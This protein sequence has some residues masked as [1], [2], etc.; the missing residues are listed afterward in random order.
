L[1]TRR[2][3]NATLTRFNSTE[4]TLS[5]KIAIH[6]NTR[7]FSTAA[8][9]SE[10]AV[11]LN[12][13]ERSWTEGKVL[14]AERALKFALE[15]FPGSAAVLVGAISL[16]DV[17]GSTQEQADILKMI[18][19]AFEKDINSIEFGTSSLM[20]LLQ[21]LYDSAYVLGNMGVYSSALHRLEIATLGL[22]HI[23][24]AATPQF[25]ELRAAIEKLLKEQRANVTS[26]KVDSI[27]RTPV[28]RGF[29]SAGWE[30][31]QDLRT[32]ERKDNFDKLLRSSKLNN[33]IGSC[34][35]ADLDFEAAL[36]LMRD[37]LDFVQSH[38]QLQSREAAQA[39][40]AEQVARQAG[41][42]MIRDELGRT[43]QLLDQTS[44]F[45]PENTDSINQV[46]KILKD[47]K[48]AQKAMSPM[49]R[50]FQRPMHRMLW[51]RLQSLVQ[52]AEGDIVETAII[53]EI[54]RLL[55][56]IAIAL[57]PDTAIDK[58]MWAGY[59]S[60]KNML[61]NRSEDAIIEL[62]TLAQ[63][64]SE[65]GGGPP[66]AAKKKAIAQ[67][68]REA[69]YIRAR[70]NVVKVIMK[71]A[72]SENVTVSERLDAISSANRAI[73]LS[74]SPTVDGKTLIMRS[75]LYQAAGMAAE[76]MRDASLAAATYTSDA[77]IRFG[78]SAVVGS[79]Q[80]TESDLAKSI[81]LDAAA[82]L[83][84]DWQ[85]SRLSGGVF[86]S[87]TLPTKDSLDKLA[88]DS[89]K[90]LVLIGLELNP[91]TPTRAQ[92]SNAS[93]CLIYRYAPGNPKA[94]EDSLEDALNHL[95]Q[96]FD[97]TSLEDDRLR[98]FARAGLLLNQAV[99]KSRYQ[100]SITQVMPLIQQAEEIFQ[101]HG[102]AAPL[103]VPKLKADVASGQSTQNIYPWA[104]L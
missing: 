39:Y 101:R 12:Q 49:S 18:R 77:E 84:S 53:D 76:A 11:L 14:E 61:F 9:D 15:N 46:K 40:V 67:L 98:D 24:P 23:P 96:H 79:I 103:H 20:N 43:E 102:R 13:I 36:Y 33:T 21:Y 48:E 87:H 68:E 56:Q 31:R 50:S 45:L 17:V 57:D 73:A 81:F 80:G 52:Q 29:S 62:Q 5:P 30:A 4:S 94:V 72:K 104:P 51:Q 16:R 89:E 85:R 58:Q 66:L 82:V 34:M 97:A 26:G 25:S 35:D 3:Y 69:E 1:A 27:I 55:T 74:G 6:A 70:D 75:Q 54:K 63:K 8:A 60:V 71:D 47:L 38:L 92:M 95:S 99:S 65:D 37:N 86:G 2:A 28:R 93:A 7:R 32:A 41:R 10:A 88:R 59:Q 42:F 78:L 19:A 91:S 83:V 64:A 90:L 44:W 100:E 22:N